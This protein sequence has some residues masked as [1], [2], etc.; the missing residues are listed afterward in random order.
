MWI[1]YLCHFVPHFSLFCFA[2]ESNQ[3][4]IFQN[5]RS[6]EIQRKKESIQIGMTGIIKNKPEWK[7]RKIQRNEQQINEQNEHILNI[8][9]GKRLF[10]LFGA[11]LCHFFNKTAEQVYCF[12]YLDSLSVTAV[13][14]NRRSLALF[15]S[16]FFFRMFSSFFPGFAQDQFRA[17][18]HI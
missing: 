12:W 1:W 4:T 11:C 6:Y 18:C 3:I 15:P 2:V 17:Q 13:M 10:H 9:L 5:Y 8:S 14:L 16:L 7:E